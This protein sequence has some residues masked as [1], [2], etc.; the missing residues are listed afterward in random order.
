M[1]TKSK[2]L[3]LTNMLSYA[4]LQIVNMLVGLL[5]P[6]LYLAV[7]G[8][9]VNGIISTINSFTTYF[10]YL[11]AGLGLTLIHSL[12]KPLAEND[13][14]GTNGILTYSKKQY[15]KIS[16]LYFLLV[17]ILS[18]VFPFFKIAND[19]GTVEFIFLVFVIGLYGALD[20]Y[21]MAKY[22]VLLTADKK[23]YIISNA[24]ILAQVLR[25]V[26]VWL[27]L[28]FNIS[29][30]FV[31]IVPILTLL[32]RTVILKVY[33]T[34]KYPDYSFSSIRKMQISA[35][36]DRWDALLLQISISTSVSL[37]TIIVS[38]TLGY[39]EANVFAVYSLVISA[40]IA[41]I[42]AL[43]S[44]VA[45]MLG[46]SIAQGKDIRK[47]YAL[48]DFFVSIVIVIAFSITAI[49]IIP[50]VILYTNV[51]DDINYVV[52]AYAILF[53]VWASLYSYRI[54]VTAV[55][56]AAGI[57]RLNRVHNSVNLI[58][59]VVGG[60]AAAFIWGVTGLLI[61]M[62]AAA[63][64]RNLTLSY[65]NSRELLHNGIL[66][67]IMRQILMVL[68]IVGNFILAYKPIQNAVS[69]VGSWI[70]YA[71]VVSV[72]EVVVCGSIFA[73]VDLKVTKSV[74]SMLKNKVKRKNK[75]NESCG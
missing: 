54:P 50:F 26:F 44:G 17:V 51:V 22:R 43:S 18:L 23:E 60:I 5:L 63:L 12:F 61:V 35:S 65:V 58:I 15:Q 72:L 8:S 56:N 59:Q 40:I 38:Q 70:L 75:A 3:L 37:P 24:M 49:M 48:Y 39:K 36:K 21:S 34:K 14:D 73:A 68:I 27:L 46:R 1:V 31:K 6:R 42:S 33:V 29:V 28:K 67:S 66:K 45:P 57:Y 7:Y 13:I 47:T 4:I 16:Y 10:A 11:E 52:P 9:E 64:H 71:F 62:I 30:V 19:I 55:I 74:I 32:V 53:S 2:N 20:F 41:I 25:F 69:G